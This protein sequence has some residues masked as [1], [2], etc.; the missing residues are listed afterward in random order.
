MALTP[1]R[2]IRGH[3]EPESAYHRAEIETG[4][5]PPVRLNWNESP[6]GL[7][8]K[9]QAAYDA[10]H[11]GNVYPAIEQAELR[12]AIARYLGVDADRLIVGAGLDD[13]INT[14]AMTVIDPGTEVIINEPTFGV[15]R[16]LFELHGAVVTDIPLGDSPDYA[17]PVDGIIDHAS[18]RTRLI[19]VCNPNNPT[20]TLFDQ[21]DIVRIIESVDCLVAID[22]AY[23][24]FSG[25]SHTELADR[26]DNV[27]TLRTMSK[28]AGLAGFR[29]GY[30]VFPDALMPW[31][32][33]AAPA[34]FNISAP[35][36]AVATAS[37]DD[38][39]HL[40]ANADRIV[41]ER[42]RLAAALNALDGVT[43][44]P[45]ATNF[46]L[47]ALPGPDAMPF[48]SALA[49]EG[50]LVRGYDDPGLRHTIRISIGLPEHHD[51][52]VAVLERKIASHK[53][54]IV[55]S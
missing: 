13:V 8:P 10:F 39:D 1:S 17:L 2:V 4:G 46:L 24:E 40:R 54:G 14:L 48:V 28:F 34:F 30:G 16:S 55:A 15:Y 37:L 36:A 43:V 25:V 9:A 27:I 42:D 23:A 11:T 35:A 31:F 22:E 44:I 51:Q 3:I 32:R 5:H 45:S 50:L 29:V 49:Q 7:S 12:L 21:E 18:E 19:I 52:L 20:G 6:F 53:E 38:L 33:R 47:V 41:S 26:Y